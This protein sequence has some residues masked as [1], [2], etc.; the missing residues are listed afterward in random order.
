MVVATA[1]T[2]LM[3]TIRIV[4]YCVSTP[5]GPRCICDSANHESS[6]LCKGIPDV[7]ISS[8]IESIVLAIKVTIQFPVVMVVDVGKMDCPHSYFPT[9][10]GPVCLC[11]SKNNELNKLC[12]GRIEKLQPIRTLANNDA[13]SIKI[14]S[15]VRVTTIM[16]K[17]LA[18]KDLNAA[19]K[20]NIRLQGFIK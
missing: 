20:V 9:P 14:K 6:P 5:E 4:Q 1:W 3:K 12:K 2:A 16:S 15:S 18:L 8:K 10:N 17:L 7:V 19:V 13:P 11:D